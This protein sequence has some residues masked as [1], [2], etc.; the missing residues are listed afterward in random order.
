MPTWFKALPWTFALVVLSASPARADGFFTPFYGYNY[1]GDSS[2]CAT[3]T[4]CED[5]R[6]NLGVSFGSMGKV[7]GYEQDISYAKEFFG[8]IPGADNSVFTLMSN[9]LVG[10]GVGPVQPYALLG[11]GL[12]RPRTSLNIASTVTDFSKNS[13]GYDIGGGVNGYFSRHVGI[14]G[15]IRRFQTM[16]DVPILGSIAGSILSNQKLSFWRASIGLALH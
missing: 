10:V 14:R 11:F 3:L 7:I 5:K 2:N 16:Q 15:D 12:V 9:V 6:T 8:K 13:F 4:T 1:G